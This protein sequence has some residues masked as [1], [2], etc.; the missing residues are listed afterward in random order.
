MAVINSSRFDFSDYIGE[1]LQ[2]YG[3]DVVRAM[4]ASIDEVARESVKKLR[5]SSPRSK[6]PNAGQYAKGWTVTF[7]RG[8]L[9]KGATI[10]GESGTYQL[11]H[12][13]EHGHALRQGGRTNEQIHIEPVEKWAIDEVHERT[14]RRLEAGVR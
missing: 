11:A 8:R 14:V 5:A 4:E 2:Q 6:G 13:L 3:V 12:L 7:E 9:R 10:H 1:M